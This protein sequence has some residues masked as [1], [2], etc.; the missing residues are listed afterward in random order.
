MNTTTPTE[1]ES[2]IPQWAIIELMGHIRYGG[3]VSKDNMFSTPML[4]VD[5]PIKDGEFMSQLVNPSSIYRIS[6][7]SEEIARAAADQ[8]SP[9]PMHQW[10]VKHL[11]PPSDPQ[12]LS[13]EHTYDPVPSEDLES[14]DF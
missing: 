13:N 1:T 7:C 5:V 12:Q 2:T 11:L 8:G 6:F 4:R 14:G 3:R 9:E 10:E